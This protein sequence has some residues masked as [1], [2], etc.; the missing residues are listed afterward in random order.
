MTKTVDIL[1][2]GGGL[3]GATLMLSL[4][5]KG[6]NTLLVDTKPFSDRVNADFDAR[7]LA[8][9]PASVRILQML[10]IWPLLQEH[11]TPIEKIHVSERA[12]F[13]SA[14]LHADLQSPLGYIVEMQHIN[15]ALHQLLNPKQIITPATVTAV[16]YDSAT[17]TISHEGVESTI[18]A[19]LIVA[20]DGT[21]STLRHL[22]GLSAEEKDFGQHGIVANIGLARP[23]QQHAYERFTA[24]GPLAL[25]PMTGLRAAL[26]WALPPKDAARLALSSE[27][28]FLKALQLAFGYRLGR[29]V[30]VGERA[31]YPLKQVIMK[32]Q[33]IGSVVFVGNAAHTIHPV[34]GQGFNLGLRDVATL[35][36]C[37]AQHGVGSEMLSL[38]EQAR[39]HD[40]NTIIRF[41]RSLIALF[42]SQLP[43]LAVARGA[44]LIALDNVSLLK[45]LLTRYTRGFAG[46][47][48]DLVCGIPLS[49]LSE[50][51]NEQP[52]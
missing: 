13:G 45:N 22:C 31:V 19:R 26:V 14:Q 24:S 8:L 51:K 2:V 12:V 48:P 37:I 44:G 35:A 36:Q 23:H 1:I 21:D 25:L 49:S 33:T 16:N 28:A 10:K 52:F 9:S 27:Q 43:G 11:A 20:A 5:D 15:R 38:Y 50:K 7:T 17:V 6:Y 3:T 39:R 30:K 47:I 40:Q 34:A 41:T 46:V 29:F 4:S 32:Q 18:K 42:T